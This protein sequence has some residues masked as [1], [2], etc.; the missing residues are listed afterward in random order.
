MSA[1]WLVIH[2]CRMEAQSLAK[3]ILCVISANPLRYIKVGASR[4]YLRA[5]ANLE[6]RPVL[7]SQGLRNSG[8]IF[9]EFD[10]TAY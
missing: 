10:K 8:M 1:D 9:A 2:M 6:Y 5:K 3:T 4:I 7:F